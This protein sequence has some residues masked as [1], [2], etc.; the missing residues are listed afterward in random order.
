MLAMERGARRPEAEELVKLTV[1]KWRALRQALEQFVAKHD[2]RNTEPFS[3][4]EAASCRRALAT[5]AGER[6]LFGNDRWTTPRRARSP[7]DRERRSEEAEDVSVSDRDD[8]ER[9]KPELNLSR[10]QDENQ[11]TERTPEDLRRENERLHAELA[12][13]KASGQRP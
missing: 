1:A 4:E 13:L 10:A 11:L 6:N 9:R 8:S 12:A 7:A 5:L 3:E 2:Y